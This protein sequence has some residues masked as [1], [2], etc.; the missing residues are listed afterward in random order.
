MVRGA[1][2]GRRY[3]LEPG[4]GCVQQALLRT[5]VRAREGQALEVKVRQLGLAW[6]CISELG[7]GSCSA[8]PGAW[9]ATSEAH[10]AHM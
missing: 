7:G 2:Q 6:C 1:L 9:L 10:W 4:C 8:W 5:L 3:S